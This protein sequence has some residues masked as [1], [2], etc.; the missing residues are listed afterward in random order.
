MKRSMSGLLTVALMSVL[1]WAGLRPRPTTP[2]NE[3]T[4]DAFP[5]PAEA[6]VHALLQSAWEGDIPAYLAAFARPM[7]ERLEREIV[8]RGS[9]PF[10]DDLRRAARSRK[11]HAV[12]A[13][14]PE[15]PDTATVPVETVYPDRTERQSYRL[16]QTLEGWV[17]TDLTT[18]RGHEPA[19]RFGSTASFNEPEGIPVEAPHLPE[20]PVESR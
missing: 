1:A 19:A 16:K 6:R 12:F 3:T 10:A 8:D 4:S 5:S 9:G 13:A 17:V 7:R 15:G 20:R 14:E 18:I 11:S 2:T